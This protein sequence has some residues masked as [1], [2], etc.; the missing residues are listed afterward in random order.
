MN[1]KHRTQL[2]Y[3]IQGRLKMQ[4]WKIPKM[5]QKEKKKEK[6]DSQIT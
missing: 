3:N 4:N 5:L 6:E 1:K 2:K